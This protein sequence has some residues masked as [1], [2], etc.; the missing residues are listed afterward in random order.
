MPTPAAAPPCAAGLELVA[1]VAYNRPRALGATAT[2]SC[3]SPCGSPSFRA[4]QCSPPSVDLKSPPCGP[5]YMVLSSQ[6]P[7]RA[8]QNPAYR[9]WASKGSILMKELPVF[10]P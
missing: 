7:E 1:T 10:S 5:L 3:D 2:S 9:I 4:R 8:F 6:G